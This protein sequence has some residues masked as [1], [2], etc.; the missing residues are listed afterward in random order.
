[1]RLS[2][3]P[4][5]PVHL[6]RRGWGGNHGTILQM[7]CR[8]ALPSEDFLES[9]DG[10]PRRKGP[11]QRPDRRRRVQKITNPGGTHTGRGLVHFRPQDAIGEQPSSRK[12]GPVP[13]RLSGRRGPSHFRGGCSPFSTQ[14]RSAAKT[15]TVLVS[16][17]QNAER[18]KGPAGKDASG[19]AFFGPRP[20]DGM[21]FPRG[22]NGVSQGRIDKAHRVWNTRYL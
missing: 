19:P 14:R 6:R 7:R 21:P 2:F 10:R 8:T 18:S 22:A 4:W 16:G 11:S 3:P 20:S 9:A 13:L 1:M 12:H 17:Y 15:G 5:R